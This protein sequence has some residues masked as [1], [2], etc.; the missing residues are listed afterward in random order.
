MMLERKHIFGMSIC[1]NFEAAE[2]E[3]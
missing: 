1:E 2:L 3:H